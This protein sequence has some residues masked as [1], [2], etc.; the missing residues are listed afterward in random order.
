ME[1]IIENIRIFD[2]IILGL[3]ITIPI[4]IYLIFT[5]FYFIKVDVGYTKVERGKHGL[6]RFVL[7][8]IFF[9]FGLILIGL[10]VE[11]TSAF[12]IEFF[13]TADEFLKK[14][15]F[16]AGL[17]NSIILNNIL[18]FYKSVPIDILVNF[19]ILGVA[20]Y[21]GTE[22]TIAS[23]KTLKL[24]EGTVVK[25]PQIKRKR[26]STMFI[27]WC[28]LSIVST[29]YYFVIGK[30]GIDFSITN[31]YVGLGATLSI[32]FI[33]ERGPST[34]QD[35]TLKKKEP[36]CK[37]DIVSSSTDTIKPDINKKESVSVVLNNNDL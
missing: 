9:M 15:D 21:T 7:C 36:R 18:R 16:F 26:L 13:S 4:I 8:G 37:E 2:F 14:Y 6:S 20:L 33:A 1:N 30:D 19:T 10:G 29:L 3:F 24:D 11:F 12:L 17:F 27:L 28:Y 23:I 5:I 32:L 34:L 35:I 22:G 25:L 31:I